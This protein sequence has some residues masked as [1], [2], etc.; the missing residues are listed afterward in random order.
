MRRFR[1]AVQS[2]R[3]ESS[4]GWRY[5]ASWFCERFYLRYVRRYP[6]SVSRCSN[7]DLSRPLTV[8]VPAVDK[9]ASV[10]PLCLRAA[11]EMIRQTVKSVLV[12]SP[13]SRMIRD[14]AAREAC[15]FVHEDEMLP[16]S[17]PDLKTRGWILQQLIK[18]NAASMVETEDYLVLDSDTV[19]LRPQS[20][21][22]R[23]KT[24]LKFS[25]QYELNYNLSLEMLLGSP[26]RFPVS[27][28]THHMIFNRSQVSLLLQSVQQ[29]FGRPWHE[30]LV[31]ELDRRRRVWFSE[32]EVYGNFLV[33]Q[34]AF[35]RDYSLRYWRG[36]DSRHSELGGFDDRRTKELAR[37]YDSV[38][39]HWHTQ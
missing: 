30:A 3:R 25:D 29:R 31:E 33:R 13:E 7:D 34:K 35:H 5:G 17:A 11:R 1:V 15:V 20:F 27:F 12:V 21:F 16:G 6:L 10:L 14:I 26:R 38:S 36:L 8:V 2:F 24:I 9:D 19:F 23:G 28:V 4:K 22:S 32:F 39:F 37:R 18:F